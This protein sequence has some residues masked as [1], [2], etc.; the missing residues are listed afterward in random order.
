MLHELQRLNLLTAEGAHALTPDRIKQIGEL[1]N[2]KRR[3][4]IKKAE[5]LWAEGVGVVD[6]VADTYLRMRGIDVISPYLGE[7][8]AEALRYHSRCEHAPGVFRSALLARIDCVGIGLTAL[9]R[10]YLAADG[11]GKAALEPQRKFLGAVTGGAVQFNQPKRGLWLVVGEGIETTLSVMQATQLPGWAALSAHG[12]R[13]LKLPETADHV[14]IAADND[15]NGVGQKAAHEAGKRF[16]KE[17][18]RVRIMLPP[19][20]YDFN[21]VLLQRIKESA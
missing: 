7:R 5:A 2:A 17:G 8:T 9:S 15:I 20:G 10:T 18:R 16:T 21:D 3:R 6:T 4:E 13:S 19:K 14:L 11:S 1:E 12:I